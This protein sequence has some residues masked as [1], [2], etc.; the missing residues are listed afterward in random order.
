MIAGKAAQMILARA[1]NGHV[2][3]ARTIDVHQHIPAGFLLARNE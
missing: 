2:T 3:M 1:L